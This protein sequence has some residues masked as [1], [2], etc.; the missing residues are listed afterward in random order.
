MTDKATDKS[1]AKGG[2]N[3][4]DLSAISSDFNDA[5]DSGSAS[6]SG[7][8]KANGH[9]SDELEIIS[10]ADSFFGSLDVVLSDEVNGD[11][12]SLDIDFSDIADA[13]SDK[14]HD[15]LAFSSDK[16]EDAVQETVHGEGA[17]KGP[18][19][20]SKDKADSVVSKPDKLTL[21]GLEDQF[22]I[23]KVE[24]SDAIGGDESVNIEIIDAVDD[25]DEMLVEAVAE[26]TE[27][28]NGTS[29][30]FDD[31]LA[32]PGDKKLD[33]A[34]LQL[35]R[36]ADL[37]VLSEDDL[38]P[39]KTGDVAALSDEALDD[40]KYG[41][42]KLSERA[43]MGRIIPIGEPIEADNEIGEDVEYSEQDC[44]AIEDPAICARRRKRNLLIAIICIAV[45][46]VT[47]CVV[48]AMR[49]YLDKLDNSFVS[50]QNYVFD[51]NDVTWDA[52]SAS[53]SGKWVAVCN[54]TRA[55]VYRNDKV[56][57]SFFPENGCQ[58]IRMADDGKTVSYVSR[59]ST[60]ERFMLATDL[61]FAS[62]VIGSFRGLLSNAFSIN[63]SSV[64]YIT[65]DDVNINVTH[66]TAQGD[67]VVALPPDA[68]ICFGSSGD[69][70]AYITGLS[71]VIH[72]EGVADMNV[73]LDDAKLACPREVALR[74]AFDGKDGWATVCENGYSQGRGN[75][76][77]AREPY[78]F[79]RVATGVDFLAIQRH[80]DGTEIVMPN[81]WLRLDESGQLSSVK[82][83]RE[84]VMPVSFAVRNSDP[85]PLIGLSG[86]KLV[87]ISETGV[88]S[89]GIYAKQELAA[90]AFVDQGK[91]VVNLWRDVE[92][93]NNKAIPDSYLS[94]WD[95]ATAKFVSNL[96]IVGSVSA[97]SFSPS[98]KLGYVIID[99]QTPKL[100]FIDWSTGAQLNTVELS[101]EVVDT[102][103][104]P[105]ENHC[106][107]HYKNGSSNIFHKKDVGFESIALIDSALSVVFHSDDYLWVFDH[108]DKAKPRVRLMR[109]SDGLYSIDFTAI[110]NSLANYDVDHVSVN[111]YSRYVLF[112]GKD[113]VWSYDVNTKRMSHVVDK[114][115]TWLNYNNSGNAV[116]T[117]LG[118]IDIASKDVR[119]QV[120]PDDLGPMYW[121]SDDQFVQTK[122][123][124]FF[125]A[126]VRRA[127]RAFPGRVNGVE[128][129]GQNIGIHP[130]SSMTLSL[131][132][133]ITTIDSVSPSGSNIL[134]AM[135]GYVD[136]NWCWMSNEGNVQGVGELCSPSEKSS[137]K[138]RAK[139]VVA[140]NDKVLASTSFVNDV[141][142]VHREPAK[143]AP[144]V[145]V[146]KLKVSAI[147]AD[148]KVL[149]GVS[150]GE[151]PEELVASGV[152][153]P[154]FKLPFETT[155]KASDRGFSVAFVADGYVMRVV[156]FNA[157]D[158]QLNINAQL[159][160]VDY[161]DITVKP[162]SEQLN[163][164]DDAS[165]ALV[166]FVG[167][168]REKIRTC[169]ESQSSPLT[170]TLDVGEGCNIGLANDS[171]AFDCLE[172]IFDEIPQ[173]TSC[174][175]HAGLVDYAF[176]SFDIVIP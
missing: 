109:L 8:E 118:I 97:M 134:A 96:S 12:I 72:H 53:A 4:G 61:G 24:V 87:K 170:I 74:C 144:F 40:C 161:Q 41:E 62:T 142:E 90:A 47:G 18:E 38:D 172:P 59:D 88:V 56:V 130:S 26:K 168:N 108:E 11:G 16:L 25:D 132:D 101:D 166:S 165:I 137:P 42:I 17:A 55:V 54:D 131:R 67:N 123:G 111:R 78:D 66:H 35:D 68:L 175:T 147:P 155:L 116:A 31:K 81:D 73:S 94:F 129:I 71:L 174:K 75:V 121:S 64:T 21:D 156:P 135:S 92:D 15:I 143:L 150:G 138:D 120:Y 117:N 89:Q 7:S 153:A 139:P 36:T 5:F 33:D 113:G 107:V 159:L 152:D 3:S 43:R 69:D 58:A 98:G 126:T 127:D 105:D 49:A 106:I 13:D 29:D 167:D 100:A 45:L 95:S 93:V 110:E 52:F 114:P 83:N 136:V 158:V 9:S 112:W 125:F 163:L 85:Q 141:S 145:D 104:S 171:N 44:S 149:F 30:G 27:H 115:V 10:G 164:S 82:F 99:A 151:K 34:D 128:F 2:L 86:G 103:W 60:L 37:M 146:T 14:L 23:S 51:S 154:F 157:D 20:A 80:K 77:K 65:Q 160:K 32:I 70:Y 57:A 22:D 46:G 1:G 162:R 133:N 39:D 76:V 50:A 176:E 122:D 119:A 28:S 19:A 91:R 124:A 148:A 48:Y 79:T 6:G 169:A 63:E 84:L 173:V 140:S 102:T